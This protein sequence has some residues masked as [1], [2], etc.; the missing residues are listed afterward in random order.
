MTTLTPPKQP[1]TL[2]QVTFRKE[3]SNEDFK[4]INKAILKHFKG[5]V[6]RTRHGDSMPTKF[7]ELDEILG[8]AYTS[9]S[10]HALYGICNTEAYLDLEQKYSY[11][12]FSITEEGVCVAE[13][14]DAEENPLFIELD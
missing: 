6:L 3:W 8:L 9:S 7:S 13:C 5:R 14:W 4:K 10:N 12:F 11:Q 2:E 1:E